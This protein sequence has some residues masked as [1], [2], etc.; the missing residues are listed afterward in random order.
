MPIITARGRVMQGWA[1]WIVNYPDC[2]LLGCVLGRGLVGLAEDARE[3]R[4][5]EHPESQKY[6]CQRP[7]TKL[8]QFADT[9]FKPLKLRLVLICLR[10]VL[11]VDYSNTV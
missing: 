5:N 8:A 1:T 2:H 7:E 4:T 6:G 11:H 9:V 10:I 3:D